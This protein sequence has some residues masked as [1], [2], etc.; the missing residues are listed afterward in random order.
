MTCIRNPHLCLF[1][2]CS[3]FRLERLLRQTSF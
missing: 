3:I 2:C 1:Q